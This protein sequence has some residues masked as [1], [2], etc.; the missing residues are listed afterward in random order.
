[1]YVDDF[2]MVNFVQLC[3]LLKLTLLLE[4]LKINS[5]AVTNISRI[6]LLE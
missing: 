6:F 1:M 3:N 2:L 4:S 5:T